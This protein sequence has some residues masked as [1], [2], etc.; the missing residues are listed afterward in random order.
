MRFDP[1]PPPPGDRPTVGVLYAATDAVTSLGETSQR[2]RVVD[3]VQNAPRLMGWRPS[4]PLTLLDPTGQWPVRNGWRY[5]R[6][7]VTGALTV[8]LPAASI[9]RAVSAN[10]PCS[11]AVLV[12]SDQVPSAF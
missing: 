10:V 3:R 4:R 1:H 8:L 12:V 6:V 2:R 7:T 11:P 5:C 9:A